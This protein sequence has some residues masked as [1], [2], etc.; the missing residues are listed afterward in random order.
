MIISNITIESS[1][2]DRDRDPH[3]SNGLSSHGPVERQKEGEDEQGSQD[4]KGLVHPLRQ[5][6][7]SNGSSPNPAGLG[8]NEH[9]I[10]PDSLTVV[11]NG[12]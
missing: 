11:D 8:L 2:G 5:S 1:D 9:V 10:K 3:Q 7:C 12:G 6:A 4:R